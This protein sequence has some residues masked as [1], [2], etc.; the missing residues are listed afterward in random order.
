M[1]RCQESPGKANE[2]PLSWCYKDR[3]KGRK[4]DIDIVE[5]ERVL[6]T[7]RVFCNGSNSFCTAMLLSCITLSAN[8]RC[9]SVSGLNSHFAEPLYKFN[10]IKK[11][12]K[13]N[14]SKHTFMLVRR[15]TTFRHCTVHHVF[16][17]IRYSYL[18][19]QSCPICYRH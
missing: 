16:K 7:Y 5:R 1:P 6:S 15:C 11:T 9:S 13:S 4:K 2:L 14:S 3:E 19:Q 18:G 8:S 10:V 12:T 17:P